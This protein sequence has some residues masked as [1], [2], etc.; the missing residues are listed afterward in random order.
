MESLRT[1]IMLR[2]QQAPDSRD[3]LTAAL[4]TLSDEL[5]SQDVRAEQMVILL[6]GAWR[7]MLLKGVY[8][9]HPP[10]MLYTEMIRQALVIFYAPRD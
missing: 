6:R 2:L 8:T 5:I 4:K 7:E 1:A 3:M 9:P 10:D